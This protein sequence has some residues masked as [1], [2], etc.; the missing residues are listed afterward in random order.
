MVEQVLDSVKKHG[1][2]GEVFFLETEEREVIF[3]SGILK[4]AETK[5]KTG[6]CLR[7][8]S[9]GRLGF[10]STTDPSRL[11]DTVETARASA[12]FGKETGLVFPSAGAL[13]GVETFDPAVAAYSQEEAVHEGRKAIDLLRESCPKARADV[14]LAVT[15]GTVRIAN[16]SGLDISY[17]MT[18]LRHHIV[19][20][21]IEGDSILW[22]Y[23]GG[24]FGDLTVR[25]DEYVRTIAELAG[26]SRT[27]APKV[28][29]NLP[30]LV[31]AD[32]LPNLVEA[33]K[34]GV[35]GRS[36]V[37]GDSPL[38]GREGDTV[39]GSVSITDNPLEAHAAGARPFDAE[40]TPSAATPVF[41]NGIFRTF[42][43]DLDT[44]AD[45]SR[46]ST[47]NALRTSLT[48]PVP[49]FSNLV[50]S[51]GEMSR[52]EMIA[53]IDEG[54]I[55]HGVLGGGQSNLLAGDFALNVMLG[56]HVKHG[57]IAGRV[58]DTMLS[59]N[60][61]EAFTG[62]TLGSEGHRVNTMVV[63]DVLFPRL[64]VSAS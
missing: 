60:V 57:E 27:K 47:G 52:A 18:S 53:G 5:K 38:I 7:I 9:D 58:T 48:P 23:E 30:V 17:T 25:T 3:D 45:C 13:P 55:V 49:G 50:M 22:I 10:S 16:T 31:T 56:F 14:S 43:F 59:G 64:S 54:V 42:L 6:L 63:P 32:V 11:E 4:S 39:L 34:R 21:I 20:G 46:E 24:T 28:T 35:N 15:H 33:I 29:G 8:V 2:S 41:D 44:A 37:T 61:Y 12:K 62:A 26:Y 51:T 1:D 40:G 36:L 19:A